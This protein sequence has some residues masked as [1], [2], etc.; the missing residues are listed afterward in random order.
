MQFL[1]DKLDK[2]QVEPDGV[3]IYS[4]VAGEQTVIVDRGLN[5][6]VI[7]MRGREAVLIRNA[8]GHWVPQNNDWAALALVLGAPALALAP[9]GF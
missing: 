8:H 4:N 6:A 9:F 5:R 2:H 1:L 3:E 7:R